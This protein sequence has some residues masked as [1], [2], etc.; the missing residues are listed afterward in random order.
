VDLAAQVHPRVLE[1]ALAE[2]QRTGLVDL[3]E[4]AT[5]LEQNPRARGAPVLRRLLERGE[6]LAFTRSGAEE[7]FLELI[8]RGGLP[9]PETNVQ[10]GGMEVDFLWRAE[11]L[12]VEVDGFA[13]HS[14]RK[15][16][17]EDRRRDAALAGLGLRTV[18]VTWRQISREPLPV[19]VRVAQILAAARSGP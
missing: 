6:A 17:E 19:L 15:S 4:V 10:V 8:G 18:R 11:R 3:D 16:F 12:V 1:Q 14:S 13:Y 7:R 2:A 9:A 5:A